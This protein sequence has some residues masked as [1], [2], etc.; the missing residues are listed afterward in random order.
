MILVKEHI[1]QLPLIDHFSAPAALIKCLFSASLNLLKSGVST[2][3]ER[4]CG[5]R[6]Q[7]I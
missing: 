7:P 5:H 1:V 2:T 4:S 6:A 3:S